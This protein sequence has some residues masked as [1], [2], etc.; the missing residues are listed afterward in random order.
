V[1]LMLEWIRQFNSTGRKISFIH[2][3]PSLRSLAELYGVIDLIPVV[4]D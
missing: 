1:S 3:T 2:L 4:G